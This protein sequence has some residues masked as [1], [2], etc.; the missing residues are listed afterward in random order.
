MSTTIPTRVLATIADFI[1]KRRYDT[2]WPLMAGLV[3]YDLTKHPRLVRSQTFGDNDYPACV[4]RFL[5]AVFRR[6]EE[7]A[8]FVISRIVRGGDEQD[9]LDPEYRP[10]FEALGI[11]PGSGATTRVLPSIVK[12][13]YLDVERF[14]HD[15][16]RDLVDQINA[17]YQYALYS[18]TQI[19]IRKLLENGL[20]DILRKKYGR[21]HVDLFFDTA[22]NRFH[23]FSKLLD[24][25]G[26]NIND[27]VHV[28]DSFGED[29]LRRMNNFREQGNSSAHNIN[30]DNKIIIEELDKNRSELNF[31]VKSIFR[32]ID[33]L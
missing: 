8:K 31:I 21:T 16:Y 4:L 30:L 9:A 11:I 19:L 22:K 27:F 29:L 18:A 13:K 28:K 20:I 15:F 3:D 24:I 7:D 1:V 2:S 14:P 25:A 23:D 10:A 32:T 26:K 17:S 6:N 33:N 12:A 5:A